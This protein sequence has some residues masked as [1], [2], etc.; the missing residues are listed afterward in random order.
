M[1]ERTTIVPPAVLEAKRRER[2]QRRQERE[3]LQGSI[4]GLLDDEDEPVCVASKSKDT[5][6]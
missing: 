1:T 2:D 3:A 4:L 6:R 5:T